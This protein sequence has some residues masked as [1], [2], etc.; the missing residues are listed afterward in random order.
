[1][2]SGSIFPKHSRE[3]SLSISQEFSRLNVTLLIGLAKWLSLSEV[4]SL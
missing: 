2:N 4:V 1:M 3:Y